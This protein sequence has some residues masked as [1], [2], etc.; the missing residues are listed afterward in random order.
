MGVWVYSIFN[1]KKEQLYEV[2]EEWFSEH[3]TDI[4]NIRE[5]KIKKLI[6]EY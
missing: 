5:E 4:S 6:N 3:F 1:E 2:N